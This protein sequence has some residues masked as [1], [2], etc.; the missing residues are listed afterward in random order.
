MQVFDQ[1]ANVLVEKLVFNDMLRWIELVFDKSTS[2][3]VRA[4]FQPDSAVKYRNDAQ[5]DLTKKLIYVFFLCIHL[6]MSFWQP[7]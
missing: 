6:W 1:L 4:G 2:S 3:F 7:V 5:L